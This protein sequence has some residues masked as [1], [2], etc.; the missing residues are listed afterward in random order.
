MVLDKQSTKS[1]FFKKLEGCEKVQEA[2]F[3]IDRKLQPLEVESPLSEVI[4]NTRHGNSK[5]IRPVSLRKPLL[6]GGYSFDDLQ[7]EQRG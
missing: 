7:L 2:Q 6:F 5:N 1:T 4:N 3:L